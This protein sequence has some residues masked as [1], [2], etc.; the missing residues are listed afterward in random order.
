MRQIGNAPPYHVI[1]CALPRIK[2]PPSPKSSFMENKPKSLHVNPVGENWEVES[3]AIT[4]GQ[5]ETKSEAIELAKELASTAKVSNIS[6]HTSDGLVET[7]ISVD[8]S[9]KISSIEQ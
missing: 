7:D 4:L 5:A 6:V 2:T 1:D 3:D 9:A 8:Q